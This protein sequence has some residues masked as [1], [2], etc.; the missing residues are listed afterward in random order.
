[1][2]CVVLY[3]VVWRQS[4]GKGERK[5]RWANVATERKERNERNEASLKDRD[6]DV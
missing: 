2:C 4:S 6:G 5:E 3:S 1:M